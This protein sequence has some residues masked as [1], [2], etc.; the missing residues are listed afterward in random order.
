MMSKRLAIQRQTARRPDSRAD[1]GC[2]R[3]KQ[4]WL[5][6]QTAEYIGLALIVHRAGTPEPN[7][8]GGVE[9]AAA[10]DYNAPASRDRAG[11]SQSSRRTHENIAGHWPERRAGCLQRR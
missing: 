2:S 6:I 3:D 10:G 5:C 8:S 4:V 11:Y 9:T 7:E 1:R